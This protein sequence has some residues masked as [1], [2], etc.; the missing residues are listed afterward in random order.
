MNKDQARR[1]MLD[2]ANTRGEWVHLDATWQEVLSRADYPKPV[3]EV[4]GQALAAVVLLSATVKHQ[5]AIVLQIRSDGPVHLLVVQATPEGDVRGLARWSREPT[6]EDLQ[7]VFGQGQIVITMESATNN[8]RYQG[9]IALE[10]DTLAAALE[11]YFQ[12]S[13]QLPTRLWLSSDSETAA[14]MLVQRL[15]GTPQDEDDWARIG[16]L[17]DTLTREELFDVA[18]E[19]LIF[20]LFHEEMPR[21]FDPR[22][23][24]FHCS[25]SQ[26][27]I[28]T[29]L[30]ALGETEA[31]SIIAEQGKIEVNCE[32]CNSRYV[33]DKIDVTRL[34]SVASIS[35]TTPTI[36]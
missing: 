30:R 36:H 23:I 28:E 11:H 21:L 35:P 32:F 34:F 5:G 33:L 6:G 15:P 20:R 7:A 17:L 27:K 25:C 2:N 3:R 19:S 22:A 26:Q 9:I 31:N 12:Q 29:T 13:E 10:G 18:P 24:R 16:L 14:G 1:F 4:L 8:E